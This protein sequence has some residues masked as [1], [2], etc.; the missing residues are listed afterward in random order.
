[1]NSRIKLALGVLA[2][3]VL[4]IIAGWL[5]IGLG[6]GLL[7]DLR[8]QK[9]IK[10]TQGVAT[11][12]VMVDPHVTK[13]NNEYQNFLDIAKNN[14]KIEGLYER[15]HAG[16]YAYETLTA[17]EKGQYSIDASV[18]FN[19]K[20]ESENTYK[21]AQKT[22]E[23]IG[24]KVNPDSSTSETQVELI[25]QFVPADESSTASPGSDRILLSLHE[26]NNTYSVMIT[27]QS[28][29]LPLGGIPAQGENYT[30]EQVKQMWEDIQ[31]GKLDLCS[32]EP[33]GAVGSW[34]P[35]YECLQENL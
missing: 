1:M 3:V 6:G 33:N 4:V 15:I 26:K 23:E 29:E 31:T 30:V 7:G 28:T 12:T 11:E 2:V 14:G 8:S 35:D 18:F 24:Y 20:V 19:E 27:Y 32:L 13:V 34:S 10:T 5:S 16:D 17:E 22:F 9:F 21:E 25:R